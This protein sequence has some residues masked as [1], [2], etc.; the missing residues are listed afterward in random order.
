LSYQKSSSGLFTRFGE[1]CPRQ[2]TSE[3]GIF[4]CFSL[5]YPEEFHMDSGLWCQ[6]CL[7][8]K[9]GNAV[10][11]P[12]ITVRM[13]EGYQRKSCSVCFKVIDLSLEAHDRMNF[14][15]CSC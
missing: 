15:G 3:L 6:S 14:P 8:L 5:L 10:L 12:L 1:F 4:K 2:S 9:N 7:M 11:A 13:L